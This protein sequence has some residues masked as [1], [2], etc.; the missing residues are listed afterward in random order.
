METL[1]RDL[2]FACRSL[3]RKPGFTAA[4]AICAALGIGLATT[5]F[6]A[7]YA[8][9]ARPFPVGDPA[10]IAALVATNVDRGIDLGDLS[11]EDFRQVR[12]QS[13]SF[14]SIA[15]YNETSLTVDAGNEPERLAGVVVSAELFDVLDVIP[16]RGRTFRTDD[17]RPG[18]AGTVVL[19]HGLWSRRFGAAPEAIGT[20]IQIDDQPHQIIGV[21]PEGFAF[22]NQAQLWIPLA[23][24]WHDSQREQ[25]E[26]DVVGRLRDGVGTESASRE[27]EAIGSRLETQFPDTHDGWGLAAIELRDLFVSDGMRTI[28][29]TLLGAAL[30]VLLIACAN[31]GNLV[32]ARAAARNQEIS[33]RAA[34]G[35]APGRVAS[36]LLVESLVLAAMGGVLGTLVAFIGVRGLVTLFPAS[37]PIP[38]WMEFS[39]DLPVLLFAATITLFTGLLAGLAPA[40]Q[41]RRL[42]LVRLLNGTS[43]GSSAGRGRLR[44]ALVIAEVALSAIL[45]IC[46]ALFVRSFFAIEKIDSGFDE[47]RTVA[48]R[49]HLSGDRYDDEG[50]RRQSIETLLSELRATSGIE[51][52]HASPLI[53][54]A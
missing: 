11:Y 19:A 31:I 16:D 48:W 53:P 38:Y 37:N 46:G 8:I 22:P 26:I 50:T 54:L 6:S 29:F 44:A 52:A 14:D 23:P 33:I 10:G 35:A 28:S 15:G 25:R 3:I 51:S 43:R 30:F 9:V 34:M 42:D 49:M 36:Q 20:T 7:F 13:S 4:A 1:Y 2:R 47:A 12:E 27:I 17:D 39:L 41:A 21:M 24:R 32:L 40:L 18:A 5:I 45:L